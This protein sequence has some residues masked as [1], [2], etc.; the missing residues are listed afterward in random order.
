MA[1]LQP[2]HEQPPQHA[3]ALAVPAG[4]GTGLQQAGDAA[5]AGPSPNGGAA[6]AP[7]A[8]PPA[9]S[10]EL[11]RRLVAALQRHAQQAALQ[12][13][14]AQLVRERQERQRAPE[15]GHQLRRGVM[16]HNAFVA[17]QQ[18]SGRLAGRKNTREFHRRQGRGQR[19]GGG[20][21]AGG[22]GAACGPAQP[23]FPRPAD[24]AAGWKPRAAVPHVLL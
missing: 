12:A 8:A 7:A 3:T 17:R 21:A 5:P 20:S 2:P 24:V 14:A 10:L 19:G 6:A 1:E 13:A 18:A 9:A 11:R 15:E 22:G 4:Q 16:L 23:P